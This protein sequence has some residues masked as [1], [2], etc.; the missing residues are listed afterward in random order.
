MSILV[1]KVPTPVA[2]KSGTVIPEA[3]VVSFVWF[4]YL[5]VTAEL[6][7]FAY[8]QLGWL[9]CLSTIPALFSICN[10]EVL[11]PWIKSVLLRVCICNPVPTFNKLIVVIPVAFRFL[12]TISAPKV[13]DYSPI[14][15]T[16]FVTSG[17]RPTVLNVELNYQMSSSGRVED[18][19]Q[20]TSITTYLADIKKMT[21]SHE[22]SSYY[23]GYGGAGN[24]DNE[25][26][27]GNPEKEAYHPFVHKHILSNK[28]LGL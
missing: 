6:V 4:W 15:K 22:S 28:Y 1:V 3:V 20:N 11:E 25:D 13:D 17:S 10:P 26:W 8:S 14:F 7:N 23:W 19:L 2:C 24:A 18:G 9:L 27:F 5:R 12:V 16:K 21:Q